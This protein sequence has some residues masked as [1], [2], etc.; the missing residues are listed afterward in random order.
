MPWV[1]VEDAVMS[2]I[3]FIDNESIEGPVNI[4]GPNI[5]TNSEFTSILAKVLRRPAFF[6]VPGFVVKTVWGEMGRELLLSGTRVRP[7]KLLESGYEFI[8]NTLEEALRE[9]IG[10][11]KK[12]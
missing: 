8:H 10:K 5:T 3:Y 7:A 6:P 9:L 1:S 12:K 2:L 4:V 11:Q